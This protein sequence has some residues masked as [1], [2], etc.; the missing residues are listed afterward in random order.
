MPTMPSMTDDEREHVVQNA[1][2]LE[3]ILNRVL[4][5]GQGEFSLPPIV[6]ASALL[7][8]AC[9]AALADKPNKEAVA[10]WL[11]KVAAEI[12]KQPGGS[13]TQDERK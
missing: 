5:L 9:R 1:R 2:H 13:C 10:G 7:H 3:A 4:A 6:I 11:R 8:A 12:E